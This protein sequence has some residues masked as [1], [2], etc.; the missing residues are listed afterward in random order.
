MKIKNAFSGLMLLGLMGTSFGQNELV[1]DVTYRDFSPKHP[2]FE[3]F[4][5]YNPNT[6][7]ARIGGAA[8]SQT[9]VGL[10]ITPGMVKD[11]L[12]KVDP[13]DPSTWIPEKTDG[14]CA[15]NNLDKWF[16]DFPGN[17]VTQ[18]NKTV[19][20]SITL[21]P[22]SQG[23][24]IY[25]FEAKHQ[26]LSTSSG[27]FYPLD[28]FAGSTKEG[29]QNYG[30]E[31]G[32]SWCGNNVSRETCIDRSH[33]EKRG[34]D[35]NDLQNSKTST[36]LGVPN[37]RRHNYNFTTEGFVQFDYLGEAD[38]IFV[39]DGDDDVW[40]FIDGHLVVDLGGIHQAEQKVIKLTDIA[41]RAQNE[42]WEE[43]WAPGTVHTLKF[44][45]VE[46]QSDGSNFTL[47]VTL[48]NI[49]PS[50][51]IGP[52][53]THAAF[54]GSGSSTGFIWLQV[55]L[56]DET[57]DKINNGQFSETAV[58]LTDTAGV[59]PAG[60]KQKPTE[61]SM[62]IKSIT[63]VANAAEEKKYGV[64]YQITYER[65]AGK[66]KPKSKQ[67]VA[68]YFNEDPG[69]AGVLNPNGEYI[70]S[71][72][73]K[74]VDGWNYKPYEAI[75]AD[76]EEKVI[77]DETVSKGKFNED[78]ITDLADAS[79]ELS[80]ANTGELTISLM[81]E[82][83]DDLDPEE[84]EALKLSAFPTN[85]NGSGVKPGSY[86][87]G[88]TSSDSLNSDNTTNGNQCY[89]TPKTPGQVS[90]QDESNC[91]GQLLEFRSPVIVDVKTYDHLGSFVNQVQLKI[92]EQ[93]ICTMQGG[94]FDENATVSRLRCTN[95]TVNKGVFVAYVGIY[96]VNQEGRKIA[97]GVYIQRWDVIRYVDNYYNSESGF[98][99]PAS[100][101]SF[102][103]K[104]PYLRSGE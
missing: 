37:G 81:D 5:I 84:K 87:M 89:Y 72:K 26:E 97:N 44:F 29:E 4:E 34:S 58:V 8:A 56:S 25:T 39:F 52:Q 32:A 42:G 28:V 85:T 70:K 30:K 49:R 60:L 21:T 35:G 86:I 41:A 55:A 45:Q 78:V 102:I 99:E 103:T 59:G 68:L 15:S 19:K 90:A 40:I 12:I 9:T 36:E 20:S 6:T 38:E 98:D 11:E 16:V 23:S 73:G 80:V 83:Y 104:S 61:G 31:N 71:N 66:V 88:G 13:L 27:G 69:Q 7:C 62:T 57:I 64:K 17:D 53:I 76:V 22:K 43:S 77:E 101:K 65:G 33:N 46:R 2:D 50:T 67:L 47:E 91:F 96:P 18:H 24:R 3:T 54:E 51:N 92:S 10:T 79:G 74:P 100:R 1:I 94:N 93:D 14:R 82:G 63:P 95:Q 75:A 48:N